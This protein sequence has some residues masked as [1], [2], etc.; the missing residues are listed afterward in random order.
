[1]S[2]LQLSVLAKA[3][4]EISDR[5]FGGYCTS[6]KLPHVF[7]LKVGIKVREMGLFGFALNV[8]PNLVLFIFRTFIVCL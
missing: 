3:C 1:M 6:I 5:S 4:R 8:K 2:A 7:R